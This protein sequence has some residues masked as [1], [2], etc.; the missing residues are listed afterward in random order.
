MILIGKKNAI[1]K[2]SSLYPNGITTIQFPL[3][4]SSVA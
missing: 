4:D 2:I 3:I 1:A